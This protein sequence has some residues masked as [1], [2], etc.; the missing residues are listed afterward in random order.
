M[1]KHLNSKSQ[2]PVLKRQEPSVQ[3]PEKLQAPSPTRRTRTIFWNLELLWSLDA[4]SLIVVQTGILGVATAS[5]SAF[6]AAHEVTKYVSHVGFDFFGVFAGF[7]ALDGD[8]QFFR[9]GAGGHDIFHFAH[10]VG[11]VFRIVFI[12]VLHVAFHFGHGPGDA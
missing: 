7:E 9:D 10:H 2:A 1:T 8:V 5:T 12:H 6:F 11:H 4:W 3:A